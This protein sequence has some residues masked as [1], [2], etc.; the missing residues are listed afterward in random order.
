MEKKRLLE[1]AG[2]Q[3]N[4]SSNMNVMVIKHIADIIVETVKSDD[5]F[6]GMDKKALND[7]IEEMV[8]EQFNVLKDDLYESTLENIHSTLKGKM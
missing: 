3:L 7:Q 5:H 4:E 1:L 6:K 8:V 2:V